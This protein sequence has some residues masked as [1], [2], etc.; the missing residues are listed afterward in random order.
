MAV[1]YDQKIISSEFDGHWTSAKAPFL[2][3]V[4]RVRDYG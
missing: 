4:M 2:S 1:I 3:L